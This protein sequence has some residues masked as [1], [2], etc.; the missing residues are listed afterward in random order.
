KKLA[1]D[2]VSSVTPSLAKTIAQRTTALG[3][4]DDRQQ[5]PELQEKLYEH[6]IEKNGPYSETHETL[7][8]PNKAKSKDSETI[9]KAKD[10]DNNEALYI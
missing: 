8:T 3:A 9:I 4:I 5:N 7:P 10:S 6:N 2:I 1:W